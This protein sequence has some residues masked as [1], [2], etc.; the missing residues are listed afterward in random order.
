MPNAR[1]PVADMP[2]N[3][4]FFDSILGCVEME[5]MSLPDGRNFVPNEKIQGSAY[6]VMLRKLN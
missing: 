4:P 1:S 5:F 6:L 3:S 2:L